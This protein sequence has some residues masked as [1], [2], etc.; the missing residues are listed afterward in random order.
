MVKRRKRASTGG[1]QPRRSRMNAEMRAGFWSAVERLVSHVETHGEP[2]EGAGDDATTIRA[3]MASSDAA[4]DELEA[5][6]DDDEPDDSGDEARD[7]AARTGEGV[8]TGD[9]QRDREGRDDVGRKLAAVY[10][11]V[12]SGMPE[13]EIERRLSLGQGTLAAFVRDS[14]NAYALSTARIGDGHRDDWRE[15]IGDAAKHYRVAEPEGPA[16]SRQPGP[17]DREPNTETPAPGQPAPA[18]NR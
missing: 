4:R 3:A 15:F 13:A 10:V 11:L 14:E 6:D 7:V 17:S 8:E 1:S 2:Y 9:R 18:D 16:D 5:S 12:R